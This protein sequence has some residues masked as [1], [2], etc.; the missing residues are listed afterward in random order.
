MKPGQFKEWL[1]AAAL[2]LLV[3]LVGLM[4]ADHLIMP[5]YTRHHTHAEVPSV[6]RMDIEDAK[7]VLSEKGFPLVVDKA[8]NNGDY[9]EGAVID[10]NPKPL[11]ITKPGRRVYV[12]V[13]TGEK[14]FSMPNLVGKSPQD[15]VFAAQSIG[16]SL[17]DDDFTYDNSDYYPAGVVMSQSVPPGTKINKA[18]P[19]QIVISIGNTTGEVPVP[20][21]VGKPL[22]R[23]KKDLITAG[24][25]VG[26]IKFKSRLDLLPNTVIAQNPPADSLAQKSASVD[27]IVSVLKRNP[28]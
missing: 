16:L 3:Y 9:P 8:Q 4:I 18:M 13:S 14:L 26:K 7:A 2:V 1:S 6:I 25:L 11:A 23:A 22:E 27:L 28:D 20:N 17:T 24:L 19:L 12:T 21:L 5:I 15:A 10:Q